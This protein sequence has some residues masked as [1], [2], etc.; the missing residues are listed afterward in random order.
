MGEKVPLL[1]FGVQH[2]LK[3]LS[4]FWLRK[5]FDYLKIPFGAGHKPRTAVAF[6]AAI[7]KYALGGPTA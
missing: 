1:L 2:G 4:A 3:E 5:L 6:F 7:A